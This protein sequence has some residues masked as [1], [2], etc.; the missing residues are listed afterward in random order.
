[1]ILS[2]LEVEKKLVV[3]QLQAAHVALSSY[4]LITVHREDVP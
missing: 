3:K 4:S 2:V 1:M